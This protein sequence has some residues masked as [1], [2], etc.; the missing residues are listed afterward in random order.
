MNIEIRKGKVE[1]R[2]AIKDAHQRSILEICIKD[3]SKD[4]VDAW[5]QIPYDE[6]RYVKALN[7]DHYEVVEIENKIEGFCHA[8]ILD[9]GKGEIQGLYLSP[10]SAGKGLGQKL[11]NRAFDYFKKNKITH[12]V[13]SGT[14]TA[15]SFYEKMGFIQYAEVKYYETR[16]VELECYPME[17]Q[18]K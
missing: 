17:T 12:I 3:Y 15:K 5:I 13:I 4:V 6:D 9:N 2:L 11:V 8:N 10:V 7:N 14:K 18:L 1:D 16:G